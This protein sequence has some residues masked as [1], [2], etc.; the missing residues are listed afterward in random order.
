MP[1]RVRTTAVDEQL[2]E[3]HGSR[4]R[5]R[6]YIPKK[7]W[8][9]GIELFWPANS[10]NSF[11]LNFVLHNIDQKTLSTESKMD[12][13]VPE[14]WVLK[15]VKLYLN[16]GR[17][18]AAFRLRKTL[19]ENSTTFVG[20]MRRNKREV[21]PPTQSTQNRNKADSVHFYCE[22]ITPCSYWDK[23]N[24]PVLFLSSMHGQ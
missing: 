12:L 24:I 11:P 19:L 21:P 13:P 9:F 10:S 14:A 7:P 17:N 2:L 22:E 23:K 15:M 16:L 5:F 3:F 18:L 8:K 1:P 4:F 20:T 6:M